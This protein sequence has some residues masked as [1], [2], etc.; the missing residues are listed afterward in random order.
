ML[1]A[2]DIFYVMPQD[3]QHGRLRI[4]REGNASVWFGVLLAV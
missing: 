4:T 2:G 1:S 3:G